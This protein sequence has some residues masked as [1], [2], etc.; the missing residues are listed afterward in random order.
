[1]RHAIV[2][3]VLVGAG[4]LLA[5]IGGALLFAPKAFLETSH[6]FVDQDPGLMSE[7]SAPSGLLLMTGALLLLGAI[8]L[9]FATLALFVG[10]AVYGSYGAGRLVSMG[11]HGLPSE[12]LVS[13]TIIELAI[14]TLLSALGFAMRSD[15][16]ASEISV[17]ANT[18]AT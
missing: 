2:R 7:L 10:A 15:Q 9:R 18:L 1:M 5:L 6:V 3:L 17:Y 8:R 14:A 11:L 16:S 13:A 12:S 4:A